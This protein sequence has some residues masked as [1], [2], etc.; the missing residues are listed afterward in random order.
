MQN[1]DEHSRSSAEGHSKKSDGNFKRKKRKKNL[2]DP[3]C[4]AYTDAHRRKKSGL[5]GGKVILVPVNS[6]GE[7][8][9]GKNQLN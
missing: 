1:L 7:R 8:G 6:S 2:F 5:Y 9:V 3:L 4:L